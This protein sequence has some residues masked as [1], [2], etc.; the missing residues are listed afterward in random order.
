MVAKAAPSALRWIA[1]LALTAAIAAPIVRRLG[2]ADPWWLVILPAGGGITA[3]VGAIR[4]RPNR[5]V[6]AS[7]IDASHGFHDACATL[8]SSSSITGADA[9]FLSLQEE[10]LKDL[11]GRVD[12]RRLGT[13]IPRR[14]LVAAC[15]VSL[16][17]LGTALLV[18]WPQSSTGADTSRS[19]ADRTSQPDASEASKVFQESQRVRE[20]AERVEVLAREGRLDDAERAMDEL[21]RRTRELAARSRQGT[22]SGSEESGTEA[23]RALI[24]SASRIGDAAE[25]VDRQTT[26]TDPLLGAPTKAEPTTMRETDPRRRS[27]DSGP[28]SRTESPRSSAVKDETSDPSASQ[29]PQGSPAE[30]QEAAERS[31]ARHESAERA[32]PAPKNNAAA[33]PR[34]GAQETAPSNRGSEDSVASPRSQQDGST[35]GSS[36]KDPSKSGEAASAASDTT[37]D[38]QRKATDGNRESTDQIA[39]GVRPDEQTHSRESNQDGGM[40]RPAPSRELTPSDAKEAR[41]RLRQR[42]EELSR[43]TGAEAMREDRDQ[44]TRS[45]PGGA[46]TGFA[47][48]HERGGASQGAAS[49]E[50]SRSTRRD[51]APEALSTYD[52]EAVHPDPEKP[53]EIIDRVRDRDDS[54]P[55]SSRAGR[56]AG[57]PGAGRANDPSHDPSV[58]PRF[59]PLVARYFERVRSAADAATASGQQQDSDAPRA[60][61]GASPPSNRP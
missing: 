10:T 14:P 30:R 8:V 31:G 61:V 13:P 47:R 11:L 49:D 12:L 60:G 9:A 45:T 34:D 38:A 15:L 55:L 2:A 5:R 37:P 3:I 16:L 43:Q 27:A 44:R 33:R 4:S 39:E 25:S 52:I 20:L 6:T 42:L 19:R 28:E 57:Q 18:P 32:R 35:K 1:L 22:A 53:G 46:S 48:D 51:D 40:R 50:A 21:E 41:G 36:L 26:G 24:E 7:A 59:R 23:R 56:F 58:A 54:A 17:L 29:A